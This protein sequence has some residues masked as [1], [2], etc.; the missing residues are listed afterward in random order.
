MGEC[1]GDGVNLKEVGTGGTK[2][3]DEG[4]HRNLPGWRWE[5][6]FWLNLSTFQLK[7]WLQ[8]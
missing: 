7:Q 6:S 8:Q 3:E 2:R 5:A 4:L 1:V